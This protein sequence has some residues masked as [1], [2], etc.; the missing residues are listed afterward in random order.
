[1]PVPDWPPRQGPTVHACP[2]LAPGPVPTAYACP[3]LG[4]RPAPTVIVRQ[5]SPG[6]FYYVI[7]KGFCE[8]SRAISG[9]RGHIH[10]AD[11]GPGAAFGEEALISS[12]PRNA[13]VTML[14]DGLLMRLP[15]DDFIELIL[16]HVL[17]P[18]NFASAQHD[19]EAGAV[20][21][22][23]RYPEHHAAGAFPASE[24][25][26][27]NMLRLQSN[28]LRKD[29][30]YIVCSDDVEQC[31]IGAFL[32]GERGFD[33]AFLDEP[34]TALAMRNP[35]LLVRAEHSAPIVTPTIVHFPGAELSA[36]LAPAEDSALAQ[37]E[38]AYGDTL[39]RIAGLSTLA[40][41]ER[42][43]QQTTPV[44]KYADT[45]TGLALAEIIEQLSDQHDQLDP[46]ER[47]PYVGQELDRDAPRAPLAAT[48]ENSPRDPISALMQ[49]ME[50]RLRREVA[51]AVEAQ[52]ALVAADYRLKLNRMREQTAEEIKRKEQ[53]LRES[54]AKEYNEKEQLLRSYY[55]K[56]IA[57]ANRISKQKAQLQEARKHFETKLAAANQLYREV[58]EMR[59]LLN[60]QI[61]LLDEQAIGDIPNL[62][63]AL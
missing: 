31:A 62:V 12:Q 26:P 47:S 24:N 59:K 18:V 55:K 37:G 25:I 36:P 51:N 10:L 21:L 29:F 19:V 40:E 6:D 2:G 20:W 46:A 23:I 48:G 49:E 34:V 60:D 50:A 42:D 15:K 17:K 52:S 43:M 27:V 57:L 61:A 16:E 28:R 22:D 8:V 11:L 35:Q 56:L 4:P 44:D 45:A 33:V 54:V 39:T 63:V 7:E 13:S 1:M 5:G 30:R 32:L 58:E 38:A 41:A 9:G 3:G 14:T 53:Q